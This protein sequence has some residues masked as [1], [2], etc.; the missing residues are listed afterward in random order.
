MLASGSGASRAHS[1]GHGRRAQVIAERTA[2]DD[3]AV[4]AALVAQV[5]H[6]V[7]VD[8]V[9]ARRPQHAAREHHD[10]DVAAIG[11]LGDAGQQRG[12]VGLA[13]R[14]HQHADARPLYALAL[15]RACP[16]DPAA[17]RG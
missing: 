17:E 6:E 11:D 12:L 13:Q 9:A 3:G 5:E 16:P 14:I 8:A 15:S 4:E 2:Q 1:V 10:V 7:A